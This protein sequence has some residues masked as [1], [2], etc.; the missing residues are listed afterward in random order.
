MHLIMVDY[1]EYNATVRQ[2]VPFP[3][4]PIYVQYLWYEKIYKFLH[5]W[6][7]DI[8]CCVMWINCVYIFCRWHTSFIFPYYY[9]LLSSSHNLTKATSI[10]YYWK[11]FAQQT[12]FN[13][14]P[15]SLAA[16]EWV[17]NNYDEVKLREFTQGG[18]FW[19]NDRILV[20]PK[21]IYIIYFTLITKNSKMLGVENEEKESSNVNIQEPQ[22]IPVSPFKFPVL[23]LWHRL[24]L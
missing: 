16:V 10:I 9:Y 20:S 15:V 4:W 24:G 22:F 19:F 2:T 8:I 6:W 21:Y 1:C 12:F 14:T 18:R 17:N 13:S 3:L 23:F 5:R 7:W 11:V